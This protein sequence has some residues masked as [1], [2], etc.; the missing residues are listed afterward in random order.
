MTDKT[1]KAPEADAALNRAL[2][3]IHDLDDDQLE[4]LLTA[5]DAKRDRPVD[6]EA[7]VFLKHPLEYQSGRILDEVRLERRP[8]A[9]DAAYG[10]KLVT[11]GE[12]AVTVVLKLLARC[13]GIPHGALEMLD[14]E[15]YEPVVSQ[16]MEWFGPFGL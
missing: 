15:D 7:V 12:D 5:I 4:K 10:A 6:Y 11:R 13:S 1:R 2:D 8:R 14:V 3:A 9:S 16:A